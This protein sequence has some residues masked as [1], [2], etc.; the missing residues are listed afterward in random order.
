M[1]EIAD[2]IGHRSM[3]TT[4]IYTKIDLRGLRE[5]A[6]LDVGGLL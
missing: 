6:E 2:H 3:E 5:V 4:R 1:K